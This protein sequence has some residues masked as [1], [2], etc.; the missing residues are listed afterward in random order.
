ME[1]LIT[2]LTNL[3]MLVPIAKAYQHNDTATFYAIL[4]VFAASFISHLVENHKHGMPGFYPVST[5]TSYFWNR[6]DVLGC[7]IV[8]TRFLYLY[9]KYSPS[10]T[11]IDITLTIIA[12]LLNAIS[13]YDKYNPDLKWFPYLTFHPI[14]HLAAAYLMNRFL[15]KIY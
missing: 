7:F 9:L 1:N 11:F 3:P 4:Y 13:E 12:F 2:T 5:N 6:L 14:W 8:G 10:V 15:N